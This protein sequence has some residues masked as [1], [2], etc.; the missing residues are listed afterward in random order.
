MGGSPSP[1]I[2]SLSDHIG[3]QPS[4][5]PPNSSDPFNQ[6]GAD[7]SSKP[8]PRQQ[9]HSRHQ[10]PKGA[11][12]APDSDSAVFAV[13]APLSPTPLSASVGADNPNTAAAWSSPLPQHT[14]QLDASSSS[15]GG[16]C[17]NSSSSKRG[18][19]QQARS[20]AGA[21][22]VSNFMLISFSLAAALAMA[23]PVPGKA[24]ASWSVGDV[25]VVQAFNNFAVF[26]ISGLTLK[27]DDFR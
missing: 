24:V 25:R 2:V 4:A 6:Q 14:L 26:L 15:P 23:W 1:Y 9:P 10:M 19:W 13:Q 8:A 11:N 3:L 21:F 12:P 18:R 22:V 17:S 16:N 20:R 27:S 5:D 7:S